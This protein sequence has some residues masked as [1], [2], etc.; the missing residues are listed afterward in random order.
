MKSM[1]SYPPLSYHWALRRPPNGVSRGDRWRTRASWLLVGLPLAL[2]GVPVAWPLRVA[3]ACVG[4]ALAA[5]ARSVATRPTETASGWIVADPRGITRQRSAGDVRLVRWSERFGL[6]VLSNESKTRGLLAI[7]TAEHTR[8]VPVRVSG[9][10][11]AAAVRDLF[12]H[13]PSLSDGDVAL[14]PVEADEALSAT[15]ALALVDV[16]R[17]HDRGAVGRILLSDPRGVP[18]VLEGTEL[19]AGERVIDLAAPLEWRAFLFLESAGPLGA[20]VQA[21]W[22]RQAGTEVVLVAPQ[23]DTREPAPRGTRV[24]SIPDAPPP[25]EL[26]L[27]IERLFMAPFRH[28]LDRAPRASRTLPS[29]RRPRTAGQA[30][31]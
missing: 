11:D 2:L 14:V 24:P 22:V 15:D 26:R 3:L 9:E 29:A 28:A 25:L 12:L 7:T 10:P 5:I 17:A 4:V 16:A 23:P 27:A 18:V 1:R 8:Y 13:G 31:S 21:T 30:P 19:R 6:V 20:V